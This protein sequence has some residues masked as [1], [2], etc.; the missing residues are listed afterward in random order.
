MRA[1]ESMLSL[2]FAALIGGVGVAQA[3]TFSLSLVSRQSGTATQ[4]ASTESLANEITPDGRWLLFTSAATDLV[5]GQTDGNSATD[6]FLFDRSN[7]ST[8]LISR[9]AGASTTTA[10]AAATGRAISADGR[11]IVYVSQST[12]VLAGLTDANANLDVFLFDRVNASTTLISRAAGS[13]TNTANGFSNAFNTYAISADGAYVVFMSSAT[14]VVPG[15]TD[16]NNLEDVFLFERATA[17]TTLI[18]GA[19]G[20]TTATANNQSLSSGLSDDGRWLLFSSSASNLLNGL[21][22][23]NGTF[24]LFVYDRTTATKTLVTSA[25]GDTATTANGQSSGSLGGT[26]EWIIFSTNASN[27]IS[28]VNDNNATYDAFVYHRPTA[29]ST[30]ISHASTSLTQVANAQTFTSRASS[31]GRWIVISTLATNLVAGVADGNGA[32]DVYLY[33]RVN[34]TSTL[35]SRALGAATTAANAQSLPSRIS[36]DGRWAMYRTLATN[37]QGGL[38]DSNNTYD[39]YVFDRDQQASTLLSRSA[40]LANSTANGESGPGTIDSTGSSIA[41]NSLATDLVS[42]LTDSNGVNDVF[43]AAPQ[44]LIFANGF[45]D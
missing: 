15:M 11:W 12:N 38:T 44:F 14:D 16:T 5:P 17:G 8:I 39:V 1:T 6:V 33:D 41:I 25:L 32:N 21:T 19:L 27:I 2:L 26:G 9:A 43:V 34:A 31:D 3:Q 13:A 22:D 35:M 37:I 42:G 10:N 36:G 30:L 18:S 4:T 28:G 40:T 23:T 45:E 7:Q 29:T 24:D 20:S